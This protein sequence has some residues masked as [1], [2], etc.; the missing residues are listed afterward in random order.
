MAVVFAQG[1]TTAATYGTISGSGFKYGFWRDEQ[2]AEWNGECGRDDG[3]GNYD[4]RGTVTKN[5]LGTL[6]LTG[7]SSYTGVTT[8]N[9]GSLI[10]AAGGTLAATPL[11]FGAALREAARRSTSTRPP[12]ARLP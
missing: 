1:I 2:R 11:T 6:T 5:G 7:V 9:S 12:V 3:R 10:I 8:L 4:G